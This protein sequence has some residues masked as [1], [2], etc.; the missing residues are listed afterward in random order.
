M[1]EIEWWGVGLGGGHVG[2]KNNLIL[3]F[4]F[5]F[6]TD[7]ML[8]SSTALQRHTHNTVC[9]DLYTI[10]C[11]R[12]NG[13]FALDAFSRTMRFIILETAFKSQY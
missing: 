6:L 4:F 7:G 2:T 10:K 13:H 3:S 8:Q 5:F 12:E 11:I 1:G 9:A